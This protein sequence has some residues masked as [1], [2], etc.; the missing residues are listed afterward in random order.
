MLEVIYY[1]LYMVLG[2]SNGGSFP[3]PLTAEEERE[4][5]NGRPKGIWRHG[6]N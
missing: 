6:I 1:L 4:C 3:Q 5:L 2:V